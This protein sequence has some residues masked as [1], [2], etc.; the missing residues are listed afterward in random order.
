MVKTVSLYFYT[1]HK[2]NKAINKIVRYI[3][4]Y[5]DT[6]VLCIVHK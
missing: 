5:S 2:N 3:T 1:L 6:L 4:L